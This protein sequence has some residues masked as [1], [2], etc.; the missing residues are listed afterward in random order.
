MKRWQHSVYVLLFINILDRLRSD[1]PFVP[2]LQKLIQTG[3]RGA[4]FSNAEYTP[5]SSYDMA[6][7]WLSFPYLQYTRDKTL[8]ESVLF[9]K[10]AE[11]VVVFIFLLSPSRNSMAVWRRKIPIPLNLRTHY[12][13]EIQLVTGSLRTD[14]GPLHVDECVF[15]INVSTPKY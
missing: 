2:Q 8:Q 13:R 1:K 5:A 4:L 12:A 15:P 14:Y 9:Y 7:D 10:P 6:F 3:E 11:E